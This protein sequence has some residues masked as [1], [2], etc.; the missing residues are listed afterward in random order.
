MTWK[1][2]GATVKAGDLKMMFNKLVVR[3]YE[4]SRSLILRDLS[5]LIDGWDEALAERMLSGKGT[6]RRVA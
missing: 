2:D 3:N 4:A 1:A 5:D 6:N